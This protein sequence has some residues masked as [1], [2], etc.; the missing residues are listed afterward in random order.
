MWNI[1]NVSIKKLIVHVMDLKDGQEPRY[2]D[3]PID[4][5]RN[6]FLRDYFQTQVEKIS[7]DEHSRPVTLSEEFQDE[8]GPLY[9]KV[10]YKENDFVQGSKEL[11]ERLDG[12]MRKNKRIAPGVLVVFVFNAV[13]SIEKPIL[14]LLKLNIMNAIIPSENTKPGGG[15]EIT[16]TVYDDAIP[17]MGEKL[18]KAALI[19]ESENHGWEMLV[20]DH[21]MARGEEHP[22][23]DFFQHFLGAKWILTGKGLTIRAFGALNK[24]ISN[25]F[26]SND[27]VAW[28][29]GESIYETM[30]KA[31]A[32]DNFNP[33]S[34]I[35]TLEVNDSTKA[36]IRSELNSANVLHEFQIDK[37]TAG[38]LIDKFRYMGDF[39]I[40]LTTTLRDYKNM[41]R[42]T[43]IVEDGIPKKRICIT[44]QQ[45]QPLP[46]RK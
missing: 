11:A 15:T 2:S 31:F 42:V 37:E 28:A 45:W 14:G 26:K 16:L 25:L 18:Q 30:E 44:T 22:A 10:I 4:I 43:S 41:V 29:K 33:G 40:L 8:M 36:K 23:A 38:R 6:R 5:T 39:G 21:Q 12:I 34:F 35:K 19:R 20:L 46:R 27:P 3:V 17:T 7:Q 32:G 9:Q 24:V 13:G 1:T